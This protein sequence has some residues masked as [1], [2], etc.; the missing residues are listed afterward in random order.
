MD[1]KNDMTDAL[2][3]LKWQ[4][5]LG[6]DENV[7]NIPLNR[8]SDHSQQNEVEIEIPVSTQQKMPKIKRYLKSLLIKITKYDLTQIQM[9]H[10]IGNFIQK[11]IQ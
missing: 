11:K 6:V 4:L 1:S 10:W 5:E 3:L 8:F 2:E 9:E 7:G